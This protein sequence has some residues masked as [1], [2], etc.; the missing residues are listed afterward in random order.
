MG[1]TKVDAE[2]PLNISNFLMRGTAPPPPPPCGIRH[3]DRDQGASPNG[4][5]LISDHVR[6]GHQHKKSRERRRKEAFLSFSY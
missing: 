4:P 6:L 5:S 1:L 2:P 3:R